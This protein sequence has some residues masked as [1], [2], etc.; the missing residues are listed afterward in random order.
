MENI[1]HNTAQGYYQHSNTKSSF[2]IRVNLLS[3]QSISSLFLYGLFVS[4][5]WFSIIVS[6]YFLVYFNLKVFLYMAKITH[7]IVT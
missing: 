6:Y 3:L 4:F 7:N 5:K 1:P 2:V